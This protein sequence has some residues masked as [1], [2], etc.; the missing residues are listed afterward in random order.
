MRG[1]T[2]HVPLDADEKTLG[3]VQRQLNQ[4]GLIP[5]SLL[6]TFRPY[7]QSRACRCSPALELT[8]RLGIDIFNTAVGGHY[9]EQEDE[10]GFM[11]N[12]N[13]L[14]DAAAEKNI[15]VGL[16]IHGDVTGTGEKAAHVI[17]TIGRDNIRINYDTGNCEFWGGQ[18]PRR[19][20]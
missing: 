6:R 10:A 19:P 20:G 2:E 12:I 1:W 5:V 11:A 13:D 14:A 17:Q 7:D 16:E 4:L 3:K 15:V 8:Q 18:G 9:S